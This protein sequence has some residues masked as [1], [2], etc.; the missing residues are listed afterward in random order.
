VLLARDVLIAEEQD[1]V[2]EKCLVDFAERGLAHRLRDIDVAY[3]G[4]ERV[5]QSA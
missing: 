4:S 2:G 5:R 3:L 1:A